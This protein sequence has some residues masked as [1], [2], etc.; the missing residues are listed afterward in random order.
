MRSSTFDEFKK[1]GNYPKDPSKLA[2][3]NFLYEN[4]GKKSLVTK[5]LKV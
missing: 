3:E 4:L 5:I 1:S 2:D